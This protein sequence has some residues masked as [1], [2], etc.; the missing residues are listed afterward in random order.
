MS[1]PVNPSTRGGPDQIQMF[2]AC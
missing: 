2:L 1:Q